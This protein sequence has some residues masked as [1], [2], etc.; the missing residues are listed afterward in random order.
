MILSFKDAI[1]VSPIIEAIVKIGDET[2]ETDQSGYVNLSLDLFDTITDGEVS[3]V[4]EKEGYITLKTEL[5]VKLGSVFN[6]I[7]FLS[8][9]LPIDNVRFVL[10]W[11]EKPRDLDLHLVS[12]NFHISYRD[13]KSI[14]DKG[15]LDRDDIDGV[16]PETITLDRIDDD[17]SYRLYVYNY[18]NEVELN[19]EVFVSVYANNELKRV[20]NLI[21]TD[22]RAIKVL[23]IVNEEINYINAEISKID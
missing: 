10:Q 11:G 3:L 18:S 20:I 23:E 19:D 16:G 15:K 21:Q 22:K 7:F 12:D 14:P 9:K 17:K 5:I 6:K 8:R 1:D 4:I 13:K 2:Y